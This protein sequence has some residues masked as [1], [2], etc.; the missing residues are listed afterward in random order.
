MTEDE[1]YALP[2]SIER[3]LM[4]PYHPNLE[5]MIDRDGTT[6]YARP[7]H[8][9]F[10]ILRAMER[11]NCSR[12]ELMDMCPPEQYGSFMEWLVG[13]CDGTIPVWPN[14]LL[15]LPIS[16][17]QYLMLRELKKARLFKGNLPAITRSKTT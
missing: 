12:D 2:F 17:E 8:Q 15:N 11:Y 5:V 1:I 3:F 9:E 6:H 10:L 7:S 13:Q 14:F 16:K 4:L